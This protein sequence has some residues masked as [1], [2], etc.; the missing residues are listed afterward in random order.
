[1]YYF[2]FVLLLSCFFFGDAKA[3]IFIVDVIN[4][5][6]NLAE[7]K[8]CE[9]LAAIS[10]KLDVNS[11][12]DLINKKSWQKEVAQQYSTVRLRFDSGVYR[13]SGPITINWGSEYSKNIALEI[14]GSVE[15]T[16]LSGAVIL[17]NPKLVNDIKYHGRLKPSVVDKLRVFDVSGLGLPSGP[18]EPYGFGFPISAVPTILFYGDSILPVAAWPNSHYSEIERPDDLS[19][20]DKTTFRVSNRSGV[21]WRN[22]TD[23]MAHAYWYYDWAAQSYNVDVDRHGRLS[24][25]NGNSTF[26]IKAGQRVR[27]ENALSELDVPGEWYFDRNNGK[28]IVWIPVGGKELSLAVSESI[29]DINGSSNIKISDIVVEKTRGDAIR[30]KSSVN[31]VLDNVIIRDTGNRALVISSSTACG[32]R[33]SLIENNGEGGVYL[34]GGARDKLIAANNFVEKSVIRNF[35]LRSKVYR[36]AVELDGVGQLVD[37]NIIYEGPHAAILFQGNDHK[38]VGNEIFNVVKET[39]DSGAIYVGRDFTARG[40]LI[41]SNF[42]HDI[43]STDKRYEVK[44]IYLDD[45]AGGVVIKNNIFARVQQPVFIGGGRDNLIQSNIFYNSNPPLSL[46]ARGARWQRAATFDSKGTLQKRLDA[47]PIQSQIWRDRYP[48]LVNIRADDFGYPKY[49][50]ACGNVVVGGKANRIA[51]DAVLG[52]NDDGFLFS[53]EHIFKNDLPPHGRVERA[54][55]VLSS[56]FLDQCSLVNH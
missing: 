1:M 18:T 5:P 38:I 55:F 11:V 14:V 33:S 42:F 56:D 28:L 30:V 27:L 48:S 19:I 53:D 24:I 29:F 9:E 34:H 39:S 54:D 45:Q 31:V 7:I 36:F 46:D 8:R 26:G 52:I 43:Y 13:L 20:N 3:E 10:C 12:F 17:N 51:S 15:G 41:E 50:I 49:N 23:M 21:E 37:G 40:T 16:L 32:I 47:V 4:Q 35:S 22:E 2:Y 44:G 25:R 6:A